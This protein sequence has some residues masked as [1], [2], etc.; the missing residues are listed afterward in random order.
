MAKIT[1]SFK[2][3][4]MQKLIMKYDYFQVF[5]QKYVINFKITKTNIRYL[6]DLHTFSKLIMK[7]EML[8]NYSCKNV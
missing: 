2:E 7:C 1:Y 5:I 4:I 3:N 6:H 8:K